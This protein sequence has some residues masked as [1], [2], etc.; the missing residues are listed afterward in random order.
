MQ[1][2]SPPSCGAF[3]VFGCRLVFQAW[4]SLYVWSVEAVV[5]FVFVSYMVDRLS[6]FY[7]GICA[8]LFRLFAGMLIL[9]YLRFFSS[10]RVS[11]LCRFGCFCGLLQYCLPCSIGI[12]SWIVMPMMPCVVGLQVIRLVGSYL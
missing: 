6:L 3:R 2:C 10:A 7:P 5:M 1:L 12:W 11:F 8:V 4:T 9:G